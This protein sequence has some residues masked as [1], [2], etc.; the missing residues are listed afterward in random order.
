VKYLIC[1]FPLY[2]FIVSVVTADDKIETE[3]YP[4]W[5]AGFSAGVLN[6]VGPTFRYHSVKPWGFQ[7]SGIATTS[8][9]L[10][11]GS[12]EVFFGERRYEH[13]ILYCPAG[14][15]IFKRGSTRTSLAIGAGIGA[16]V[17]TKFGLGLYAEIPFGADI[18][19]RQSNSQFWFGPLPGIGIL[20]HF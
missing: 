3:D 6:G 11:S 4:M 8:G 1:L 9:S 20:F 19:I 16:E 14:V 10:A 12:I 15:S 13:F 17:V 5:E 18:P 7:V 2:V